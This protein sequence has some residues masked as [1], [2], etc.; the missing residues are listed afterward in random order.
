[1]AVSGWGARPL[2]AVATPRGGERE[3][4]ASR[5]RGRASR[6]PPRV[7]TFAGARHSSFRVRVRV[8]RTS[9]SRAGLPHSPKKPG[10]L[11]VQGVGKISEKLPLPCVQGIRGCPAMFPKRTSF[12]LWENYGTLPAPHPRNAIRENCHAKAALC[13]GCNL[14]CQMWEIQVHVG[15]CSR[16]PSMHLF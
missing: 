15:F 8:R 16:L 4:G 11:E 7:S 3:P 13:L 5:G 6:Q 9:A 12:P 10:S 2:V 1:M 14:G